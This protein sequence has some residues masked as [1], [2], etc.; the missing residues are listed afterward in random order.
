M[1]LIKK[2]K[3]IREEKDIFLEKGVEVG[4]AIIFDGIAGQVIPGIVGLRMDYKQKQMEKRLN[5]GMGLLIERLDQVEEG[6]R[7]LN[8]TEYCF[9]EESVFPLVFEN[10]INESEEEKIKYI[11]NGFESV[12]QDKI[13]D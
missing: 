12:I 8:H 11:I 9:V 13:T 6:M 5:I 2:I 3:Q 10:I 4:S 7:K 1:N